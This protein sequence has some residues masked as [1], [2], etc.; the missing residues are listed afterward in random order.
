MTSAD[1]EAPDTARP[2]ADPSRAPAKTWLN[3]KVEVRASL[4]EGK[5]LFACEP[6]NAGDAIA[7]MGG[8]VL[9]DD[10]FRAAIAKLDKYSAAQIDEGRNIL[11]DTPHPAEY[12]NH[13]CDANTW[14]R[15]ALTTEA[16]RRIDAGEE[17]TVDYAVMTADPNWTM[18][19]NCGAGG[20]RR[21]VRG[22]DWRLPDV[23]RR[24]EGH[25]APFLNRRI[26]RQRER[27]NRLE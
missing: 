17:I 18:S 14:M 23:Q 19:C 8:S 9:S 4:I 15:D 25:F 1:H 6:I 10:E 13:S 24:Y 3:P 7:V 21:I 5:G 2:A 16:K 20:C 11:L 22:D 12:G 26:Q 27:S